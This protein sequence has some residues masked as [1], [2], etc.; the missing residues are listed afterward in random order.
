M[1]G[2]H[3]SLDEIKAIKEKIV[4]FFENTIH[5]TLYAA[6]ANANVGHSTVYNWRKIDKD[7]D[8]AIS[9][10]HKESVSLGLDVAEGVLMKAVTEGK[11]AELLFYLKTQGKSRGYV[12]RTETTGA[13]GEPITSITRTIIDTT[14]HNNA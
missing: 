12:E 11:T 7:F 3:F 10:A 6:C 9:K 1:Q 2:V 13:D 5:G 8:A 14:E 4:K